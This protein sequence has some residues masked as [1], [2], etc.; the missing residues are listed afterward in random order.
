[1]GSGLGDIQVSDIFDAVELSHQ[2]RIS[3]VIVRVGHEAGAVPDFVLQFRR[4]ETGYAH[5]GA[6]VG[7]PGDPDRGSAKSTAARIR[8]A[9]AAV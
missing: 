6:A 1:M 8:R 2:P 3:P 4:L 7:L 9:A 5:E